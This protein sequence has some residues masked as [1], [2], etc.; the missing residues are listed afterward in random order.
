VTG[1]QDTKDTFLAERNNTLVVEALGQEFLFSTNG[2]LW[3]HGKVDD[4][5]DTKLPLALIYGLYKLGSQAEAEISSGRGWNFEL[6]SAKDRVQCS[7]E[8]KK[9]ACPEGLA[10]LGEIVTTLDNPAV[11]CHDIE[12]KFI[13]N[14][15]QTIVAQGYAIK[16]SKVCSYYHMK[17]SRTSLV[18]IGRMQA[19]ACSWAPPSR[20]GTWRPGSTRPPARLC[21]FASTTRTTISCK[22]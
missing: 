3:C 15:E 14:D 7:S 9:D 11:E 21:T 19:P 2:D 5:V 4:V 17:N 13:K 12:P 16:C 1:D 6:K 10:P 22:G 8:V 18:R 20:I